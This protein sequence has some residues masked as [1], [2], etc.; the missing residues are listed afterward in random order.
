MEGLK[1]DPVRGRADEPVPAPL[2]PPR[3]GSKRG[4]A[5][6]A[7]GRVRDRDGDTSRGLTV[8]LVRYRRARAFAGPSDQVYP[9]EAGSRLFAGAEGTMEQRG[10]GLVLSLVIASCYSSNELCSAPVDD[11]AHSLLIA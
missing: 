11:L 7:G 9:L 5:T 3:E 8:A 1:H 6:Q 4:P 2:S 10:L